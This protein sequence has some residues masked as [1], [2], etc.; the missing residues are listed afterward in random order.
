MRARVVGPGLVKILRVVP[1]PL[2]T[3]RHATGAVT[4]AVLRGLEDVTARKD[5]GA[6]AVTYVSTECKLRA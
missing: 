2:K 6:R 1:T 5:T 3:Q 4:T